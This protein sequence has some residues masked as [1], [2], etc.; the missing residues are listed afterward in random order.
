MRELDYLSEECIQDIRNYMPILSEADRKA[1][2]GPLYYWPFTLVEW[3]I[4]VILGPS[5]F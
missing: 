3:P 2:F 5:G 4:E 1:I